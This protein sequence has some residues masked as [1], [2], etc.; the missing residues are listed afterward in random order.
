MKKDIKIPESKGI[1]LGIAREKN[2]EFQTMEW[3]AYI[4]NDRDITIE[5]ILVVSKGFDKEIKTS[6][7]RHSVK[8]L[9]EKSFAK[10]E[11]LQEEVLALTNEFAVT[12]FA[13]GKMYD[14]TFVFSE[15]SIKESEMVELPILKIPG[16]LK[17]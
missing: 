5:M 1:Y 11:F 3:N 13:D 16:I 2:V 8:E 4:I 10:I 6:T 7:M 12:Y 9:P 17:K 14:R 15:N